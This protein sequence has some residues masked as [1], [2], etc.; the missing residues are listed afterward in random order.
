[1]RGTADTGHESQATKPLNFEQ[2]LAAERDT[3]LQ[4][5]GRAPEESAGLAFSGGGIRS[6]TFNLGVL[7][8]LARLRL[9]RHIDYL[10][11]VSG[12]GYIGGWF[13]ALLA[14]NAGD[15]RRVEEHLASPNLNRP[16]PHEVT[17]LRR[18]SNYLTPKTGLSADT[19]T[20]VASYTRNLLLNLTGLLALFALL[21]LVPRIVA[22]GLPL[23]SSWN[24]GIY[25]LLLIMIVA[26]LGAWSG[27]GWQAPAETRPARF[28]A[29]PHLALYF[30]ASVAV[31][32]LAMHPDIEPASMFNVGLLVYT[33]FWL[34][35]QAI[36]MRAK[37]GMTLGD[38][39]VHLLC[40]AAGA[41]L[42]GGL[43]VLLDG[44]AVY[45]MRHELTLFGPP[46]TMLAFALGVVLHV[47]LAKRRFSEMEREWW[48]RFGGMV[49]ALSTVWLIFAAIALYATPAFE[50]LNVWVAG[51]G[52]LGWAAATLW[53]VLAGKSA[54]SGG[55]NAGPRTEFALRLVPWVFILGLLGLVSLGLQSALQSCPPSPPGQAPPPGPAVHDAPGSLSLSLLGS[56]GQEARFNWAAP[57]H[58]NETNFADWRAHAANLLAAAESPRTAWVFLVLLG[59]VAITAWRIDIN[60]FSF[61]NFYRH[62]LA[63]CYLGASNPERRPDAFTG[64]DANDDLPIARLAHRPY[65]IY[66]MAL[67]LVGGRELAWQERKAANFTASPLYSGFQLPAGMDCACG[68]Y[69]E[70]QAFLADDAP[71]GMRVG[72]AIAISGAAVNPNMGYHSSP[73]VSFL[74]ALFNVRLGR[75][76]GN[77][78]AS[79][80]V[81]RK[82]SPAFGLWYLVKELL[83]TTDEQQDWVNL[84]DGG[85]FENL[86]LY[87][88]VRRRCRYIVAIDAAQDAE[89]TFGDFANAQRKVRA[90]FG[91]DIDI[92][93][94]GLHA[95]QG[96]Q[97]AHAALGRIRYDRVDPRAEQGYLLYLRPG[98]C[99]GE[100]EDILSYA[101]THP[102]FPFQTTNDQWF[103]EA[104]FES[105]RKLGE[106]ISLHVLGDPLR[107]SCPEEGAQGRVN[108]ASPCFDLERL[109]A[110]LSK[111]WR[112]HIVC[113]THAS[114]QHM[115]RLDAIH[116]RLRTEPRAD[117]LSREIFP[118]WSVLL[119]NR[120]DPRMPEPPED[121]EALKHGFYLC[122]EAAQLMERVYV[123]LDLDRN[124]AHPDCRGWMNLFRHWSWSPT[125]RITWSL[126]AATFGADFQR[127]V[128]RHLSLDVGEV[129][130]TT[131]DWTGK[132]VGEL[133][134]AEREMLMPH[135]HHWHDKSARLARF[136]LVVR[137]GLMNCVELRR[138]HFGF[139]LIV[140]GQLAFYRIQDHLRGL[141]LGR[142][143]MEQLIARHPSLS[144]SDA[145]SPIP[146]PARERA[147]VRKLFDSV[148]ASR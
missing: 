105:Y 146:A 14:R 79:A 6:A 142:K 92:D 49:L 2:V 57:A 93:L 101:R 106:H 48:S 62:R 4:N 130:T 38:F 143:A 52:G 131:E 82:S 126:T 27:L 134:F 56:A 86:A 104:Q 114:N 138:F 30:L 123:D 73:A 13:A 129:E 64:L 80:R 5:G 85:H 17:W 137:Y 1:M 89:Y 120:E 127:F 40:G 36:Q 60:L 136:D 72:T 109:F 108:G 84:S 39:M 135:A 97:R 148:R 125:F 116:E 107:R 25:L 23:V 132:A 16:E 113:D 59:V 65:P 122:R 98:L 45:S 90:D 11:T 68:G 47:G 46:L 128:Q 81:W 31:G 110:E 28:S 118:E 12:G 144:F 51:A 54:R 44:L 33:I 112:G 91:I 58:R 117:Y 42:A 43:L 99:G 124:H 121:D 69:R 53:G 63:R 26:V 76:C 55:E 94:G 88:L 141:G 34:A 24:V 20:G 67:N 103:D 75:W 37:P 77:P 22:W 96:R 61:H 71:G 66:N 70:T 50:Y 111:T 9:L 41:A 87:E 15:V 7:Q 21:M 32:A 95:S 100:P 35:A 133:N 74:L 83:G 29:A 10:S 147:A 8:G 115:E 19:L 119:D 139:A 140:D 18:F 78:L 3:L 145:P 102:P